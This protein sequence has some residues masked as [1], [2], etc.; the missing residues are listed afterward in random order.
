[1]ALV[2]SLFIT[3][4]SDGTFDYDQ[5]RGDVE[6]PGRCHWFMAI[7]VGQLVPLE[8][9][10]TRVEEV[11]TRV[12]GSRRAAGVEHLYVPGDIEH[13][14]AARQ[15]QTGIEYEHFVLDDLKALGA[16]LGIEFDLV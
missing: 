14:R 11:S 4:L 12:R 9:F 2:L 6:R 10:T 3:L 8:R 13:E 5:G 1:M 15:A 7:D 16:E